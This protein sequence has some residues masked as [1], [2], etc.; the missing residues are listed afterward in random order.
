MS[1]EPNAHEIAAWGYDAAKR[2]AEAAAERERENRARARAKQAAAVFQAQVRAAAPPATAS[3]H[4]CH[5]P[6]ASRS[7]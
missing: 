1:D 4:A 6:S 2:G 3:P 5:R 7:A